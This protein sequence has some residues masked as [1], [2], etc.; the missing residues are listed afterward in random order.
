M[1]IF[2]VMVMHYRPRDPSELLKLLTV[3]NAIEP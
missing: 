3:M 2:R 1:L